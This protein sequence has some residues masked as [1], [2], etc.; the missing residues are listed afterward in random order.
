MENAVIIAALALL[1]ISVILLLA[2]V[3]TTFPRA[4]E[5]LFSPLLH[6]L[7]RRSRSNAREIAKQLAKRRPLLPERDPDEYAL[8]H[9]A[10][11]S[12]HPAFAPAPPFTSRLAQLDAR[13]PDAPLTLPDNADRQILAIAAEPDYESLLNQLETRPQYPQAAPT[14]PEPLRAPSWQTWQLEIDKPTLE[15]PLY[16]GWLSPMNKIVELAHQSEINQLKEAVA[17]FD[18]AQRDLEIRNRRLEKLARLAANQAKKFNQQQRDA[19]A[20]AMSAYHADRAHFEAALATEQ[21]RAAALSAKI[22]APGVDG[23]LARVD[24]M[25]RSLPLRGFLL[26]GWRCRFDTPT[27]TLL[28]EQPMLDVGQI[29]WQP[30][31]DAAQAAARLYPGLGLRLAVEIAR[32]DKEGLCHAIAVNGMARHIDKATG[33]ETRNCCVS[34]CADRTRLQSIHLPRVDP[35]I[36][37]AALGGIASR[38][39]DVNPVTPLIPFDELSGASTTRDGD[40]SDSERNLETLNASRFRVLCTDLLGQAFSGADTEIKLTRADAHCVHT[41]LVD[42]DPLR[43]G[44]VVVHIKRHAPSVELADIQALFGSMTT[45]AALKGIFITTGRFDAAASAFAGSKPISLL[46]G[47]EF[48][49][50][51]AEHGFEREIRFSESH[52]GQSAG[53]A[54]DSAKVSPIR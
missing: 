21:T 9:F 8:S 54:T 18:A 7:G 51:L 27:Q 37:L 4:W 39:L 42:H 45:E 15:L 12:S 43:G 48:L 46:N 19:Y 6:A 2:A 10:P 30:A 11:R 23:L 33:R 22:N 3:F 50:L 29:Q 24:L 14:K 26:T 25:L 31:Q 36:A 38:G 47:S 1:A 35:E 16:D 28:L 34:L 52:A 44:T 49:N 41:V 53:K 17:R 20:G 40:L 32:L 5:P 13:W